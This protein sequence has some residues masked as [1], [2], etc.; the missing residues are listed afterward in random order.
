MIDVPMKLIVQPDA[1]IAPILAAIRS[2]RRNIHIVIFRLDRD[3]VV[4]ALD[5]AVDRGVAVRAL[6]AH[7]NRGGDATLRKLE[8]RMLKCGITVARTEDDLVR[9]HGKVLV[10]DRCQAFI[11]GFNYTKADLNSRSFGVATRS[12]RVINELMRLFDSDA[13][14]TGYVPRVRDLVVSPENARRRLE[15]FL[16]KAKQRIDIY[17]MHISDD[18]MLE[19]L[20]I[21][22]TRGVEVR[23]LGKLEAKWKNAGFDARAYP[24]GRL[25]VRAIIRDGRRAFIG[26]QS[27]RKSELDKRREVGIIIRDRDT[28]RKMEKTFERDW[29]QTKSRRRPRS[30]S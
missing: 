16:R 23:I 15:R 25:H 5:S 3:E 26:S 22:A 18:A 17:D 24:G 14:R 20:R 19:I 28:I 2:A 11:L 7:T 30:N 27:L 8:L 4:D 6:I 10:I 13:S 1:G 29:K 12:R 9:Y 21:R